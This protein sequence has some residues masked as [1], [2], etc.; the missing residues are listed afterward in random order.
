MMTLMRLTT[1]CLIVIAEQRQLFV[2]LP[3][4]VVDML[5]LC[6]LKNFL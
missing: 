4:L 1:I 5:I 2:G 6:A 3:S